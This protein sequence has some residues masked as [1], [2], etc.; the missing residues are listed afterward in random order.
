MTSAEGAG[1]G[2]GPGPPAPKMR[3]AARLTGIAAL[4]PTPMRIC[5][6]GCGGKQRAARR[7]SIV[8]NDTSAAGAHGTQ[9]NAH[10]R[11]PSQCRRAASPR[12]GPCRPRAR[13]NPPS[14]AA[15]CDSEQR[16]VSARIATVVTTRYPHRAAHEVKALLRKGRTFPATAP[17][18]AAAA[19][20][21]ATI[22]ACA[23]CRRR[24][25]PTSARS[26]PMALAI[27]GPGAGAGTGAMTDLGSAERRSASICDGGPRGWHAQ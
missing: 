23:A 10:T 25:E 5:L 2:A 27:A 12:P 13:R 20:R 22:L 15:E 26:A 11:A 7:V 6:E 9:R 24:L 14:E 4:A 18:G 16:T 3:A 17:A 19:P 1:A 21:P 8:A